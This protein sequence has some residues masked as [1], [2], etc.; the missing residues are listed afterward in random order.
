MQQQNTR[1][2]PQV[3]LLQAGIAKQIKQLYADDKNRLIC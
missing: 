1:K 2:F 3:S